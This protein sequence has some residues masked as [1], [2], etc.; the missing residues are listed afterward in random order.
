MMVCAKWLHTRL[1]LH[2]LPQEMAIA[3]VHRTTRFCH[4]DSN[5]SKS[6]SEL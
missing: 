3:V 2:F 6:E 1:K 5:Q 4:N